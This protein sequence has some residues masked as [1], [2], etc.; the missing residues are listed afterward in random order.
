MVFQVK[1]SSYF[2]IVAI[3]KNV[4]SIK[5][6]NLARKAGKT[7]DGIFVFDVTIGSIL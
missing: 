3:N 2:S 7:S 6:E 5:S 4:C 1:K